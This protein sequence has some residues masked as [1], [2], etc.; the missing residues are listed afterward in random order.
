MYAL[1][2]SQALLGIYLGII[3]HFRY[4]VMLAVTYTLRLVW[5]SDILDTYYPEGIPL[6][7][8]VFP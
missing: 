7:R 4:C 6:A 2:Q 1:E 5:C 8:V 3:F